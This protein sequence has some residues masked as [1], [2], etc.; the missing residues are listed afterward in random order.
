MNNGYT[1]EPLVYVDENGEEQLSYD[2]AN[3]QDHSFREAVNRQ[4]QYDQQYAIREDNAGNQFHA[5]DVENP[6]AY[7]EDAYQPQVE[8]PQEEED[9]YSEEQIDSFINEEVYEA[10]GGREGYQEL[11]EFA[12]EHWTEKDIEA[13]DAAMETSDIDLM[14]KAINFLI[15]DYNEA[16]Q[17]QQQYDYWSK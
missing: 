9:L 6:E 14:R 10:C 1:V 8:E 16:L 13:F 2:H 17:E 5:W 3:V 15:E 4:H 7:D 12:K 11:I